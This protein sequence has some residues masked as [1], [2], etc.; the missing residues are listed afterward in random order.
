MDKKTIMMKFRLSP[1]LKEKF[2]LTAE[3][4]DLQMSEVIR[5]LMN[6]FIENNQKLAA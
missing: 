3:K 5:D 1:E 2:K 4:N 6:Q